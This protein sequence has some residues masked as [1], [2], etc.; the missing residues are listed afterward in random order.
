VTSSTGTPTG[1][2]GPAQQDVGFVW[3][4]AKGPDLGDDGRGT[5][6]P[7]RCVSP[8]AGAKPFALLARAL[9]NSG[10]VAIVRLVMR[11]RRYTAALRSVDGRLLMSTLAYA[12]EVVP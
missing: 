3:R 4:L 12:D 5:S 2:T 7:R 9:E 10:T 11:G 1:L 8:A 6:H